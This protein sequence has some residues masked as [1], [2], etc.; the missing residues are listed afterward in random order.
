MM[1]KICLTCTALLLVGMVACKQRSAEAG[2][3]RNVPATKNHE[4]GSSPQGLTFTTKKIS[5]TEVLHQLSVKVDAD[6]YYQMATITDLQ[7]VGP[8]KRV[9]NINAM[10]K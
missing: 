9:L 10:E 7:P 1:R 8:A 5:R 6:T 4:M 3:N 2:N